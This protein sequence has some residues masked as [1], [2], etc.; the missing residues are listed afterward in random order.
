MA[1][2]VMVTLGFYTPSVLAEQQQQPSKGVDPNDE[3]AA[4]GGSKASETSLGVKTIDIT[5][6]LPDLRR[7]IKAGK[8]HDAATR[9]EGDADGYSP[10]ARRR[11]GGNKDEESWTWRGSNNNNNNAR[12]QPFTEALAA[13]MRHHL[14][15]DMFHPAVRVTRVACGGFVLSEG[16]VKLFG[17]PPPTTEED[18]ES[19]RLV[20]DALSDGLQR[21][22]WAVLGGL[23]ERAQV[24]SLVGLVGED[25]VAL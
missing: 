17:V 24:T 21:G 16:R 25:G 19:G 11:L 13:Y 23:V 12:P 9:L 20:R 8:A 3:A 10:L 22:L 15:L 14:A 7:F 1:K 5:V 18:G 4:D 6:P 2:D